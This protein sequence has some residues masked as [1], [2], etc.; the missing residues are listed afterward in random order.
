MAKGRLIARINKQR[1]NKKKSLS[2]IEDGDSAH[3]VPVK[4]RQRNEQKQMKLLKRAGLKPLP[5]P[6]ESPKKTIKKISVADSGR[7]AKYT[8]K[9]KTARKKVVTKK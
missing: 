8:G 3:W 9:G 2:A 6:D 4:I 7:T 1:V 5:A